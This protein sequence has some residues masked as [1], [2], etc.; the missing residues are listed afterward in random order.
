MEI[1]KNGVTFIH[2]TGH[3]DLSI[4]AGRRYHAVS[5]S[6]PQTL[7]IRNGEVIINPAL[8]ANALRYVRPNRDDANDASECIHLLLQQRNDLLQ[9]AEDLVATIEL[10][11]DCMSGDINLEGRVALDTWI[12]KVEAVINSIRGN[13]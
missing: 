3:A 4:P 1:I 11:T 13:T 10:K 2:V 12:E 9:A 7:T 5:L 8:L 6:V